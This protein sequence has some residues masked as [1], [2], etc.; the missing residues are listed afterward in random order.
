MAWSMVTAGGS[1]TTWTDAAGSD[2]AWGAA[3]SRNSYAWIPY[4]TREDLSGGI[5]FVPK[6]SIE[7]PLKLDSTR[8]LA[9]WNLSAITASGF[10]AEAHP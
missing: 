3:A 8:P 2:A 10:T 9:A 1:A 5:D 4:A 6:A 7:A